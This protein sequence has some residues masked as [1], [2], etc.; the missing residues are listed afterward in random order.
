M[1]FSGRFPAPLV[2]ISLALPLAGFQ[3]L[4]AQDSFRAATQELCDARSGAAD[5]TGSAYTQALAC[6]AQQYP[7]KAE[8]IFE[9]VLSHL[10]ESPSLRILFGIAFKE[11]EHWPEAVREFERAIKL[12][13]TVPG[14]HYYLGLTFLLSK[15]TPAFQSAMKEFQLEL[16]LNPD[17]YFPNFYMGLVHTLARNDDEAM[18]YLLKAIEIEPSNPD[19]YLYAGQVLVRSEKAHEAIKALRESIALTKDPSRN[20]YQVSNAEYILGQTLLKSGNREEAVQHIKKS[21]E[22]KR[23]QYQAAQVDFQART[24]TGVSSASSGM[25]S[26][27]FRDLRDVEPGLNLNRPLPDDQVQSGHKGAEHFYRTAAARAF[28]TVAEIACEHQDFASA[29]VY[30]E[31]AVRLDPQNSELVY[32]LSQAYSRAG[33]HEQAKK[34][35]EKYKELEK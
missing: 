16:E 1:Q 31:T 21:Q 9:S 26:Y 14:A 30:L 15:G 10:G 24:L 27:D 4:R 32:Q 12:D 13:P 18:R 33:H 35:L 6:L 8:R 3:L 25:A 23:L 34:T 20:N 2:F 5:D 19:P 22:L 7:D 11:T 29:L 17:Q 28:Q